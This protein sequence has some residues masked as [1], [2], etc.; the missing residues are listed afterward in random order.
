MY[1]FVLSGVDSIYCI[2]FSMQKLLPCNVHPCL[3]LFGIAFDL[4]YRI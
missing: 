1:G 3:S 4:L 2:G